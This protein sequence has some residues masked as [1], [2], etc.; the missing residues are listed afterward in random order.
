MAP[1]TLSFC[2]P[3]RLLLCTL[4]VS[5]VCRYS[6]LGSA[7]RGTETPNTVSFHRNGS[8]SGAE[9]PSGVSFEEE[10][11]YD[12]EDDP[13][14]SELVIEGGN[15]TKPSVKPEKTTK[16]GEKR[17]GE[18]KKKRQGNKE[19]KNKKQENPCETTHKD[20]CIHGKCR[21]LDALNEVAC[22]C[23]HNYIGQ[24]CSEMFMRTR[25]GGDLSDTSTTALAIVAVLLSTISFIA[26][27]IVIA[28][29]M[30][31]NYSATYEGE[32]E[33]KKR[34]GHEN[35]DIDL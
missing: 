18:R 11:D 26:I 8:L 24:R 3:W 35:G 5:L 13:S 30:K 12:T 9:L 28:V 23:H 34:L 21:F 25:T 20:Y 19:N 15:Q 1:L 27:A 22:I 29:H 32:T 4:A 2:R 33:E 31:K 6:V 16:K 17:N 14:V 10:D 7:L